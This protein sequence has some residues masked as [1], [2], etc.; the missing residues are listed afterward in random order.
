MQIAR[1]R[2]RNGF[3]PPLLIPDDQAREMLNLDLYDGQLGRKRHGFTQD[4][5][6]F[7]SGGPFTGQIVSLIRHVPGANESAMELFAIGN[8]ATP[9][10]GR[11]AASTQYV[12]VTTKDAIATRPQ[13]VMGVS[14]NGKLLL[15]G[16][17]TTVNRAQCWDG[18]TIRRMGLATPAAPT[19]ADDAAGGLSLS[20]SYKVAYTV[21]SGGVTLRRSELGSVLTRTISAKAGST[22]TKPATISEGETHWELY[23][24]D[25]ATGIY[26]LI[27]TTVVGTTTFDDTSATIATTTAAPV[28]GTNLPPPSAKF[29]ATDGNRALWYGALESSAGDSAEPKQGRV[30]FSAVLGAS[31]TSIGDDERV[32]IQSTAGGLRYYIDVGENDGGEPRGLAGPLY[33]SMYA[34]QSRG[35]TELTPT[36]RANTPYKRYQA[37][38]VHGTV[39][40]KCIVEATDA[41]G[42]PAL[43]FLSPKD[44]PRR[45]GRGGVEWCGADVKDRWDLVNL[46]AST[47]VAHGVY[48]ADLNQVWW[49]VASGS[50]NVPSD[51]IVFDIQEGIASYAEGEPAIR[52]GWTRFS[53]DITAANCSCMF[54]VTPGATMARRLKPYIG[55]TTAN[56]VAMCD[57]GTIDGTVAFQAYVQTKPYPLTG[58]KSAP[59]GLDHLGSVTG[60][61]LAADPVTGVSI[62]LTVTPEC[63]LATSEVSPRLDRVVLTAAG[64]E[65]IALRRFQACELAGIPAASFLLGDASAIS[66]AWTLHALTVETGT[67]EPLT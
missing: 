22:I 66:N 13:D 58:S 44:G 39:N 27:A 4:V 26:Y 10:I 21:Q 37:S 17:D 55:L 3:D 54:S 53:G 14:F 12:A 30:W 61:T 51:L 59:L 1:L 18:S 67:Q 34:F 6:S 49:W 45:I 31:A 23:A 25:T 56:K 43:Y 8:E 62:Q 65:T 16:Y 15:A 11:K 9:I 19:G 2:G 57:S 5:V 52:K 29:V 48:H 35:F 40:Q 24:A 33:G 7:S 47:V 28:V 46:D 60:A 64:S 42:N 50:S 63:L 38:H 20:R 41:S 36:G 32:P